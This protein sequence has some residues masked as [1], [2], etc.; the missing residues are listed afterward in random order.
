MSRLR[1]A[2][3]SA[4][5]AALIVA[6]LVFEIVTTQPVRGAIQTC[7]ELLTI[8][9][10]LEMIDPRR[11]EEKQ[12]ALEA[13]NALCSARF[14]Q[15][16]PLKSAPEG[17]I[18]GIPRNLHKNFRA[19][20]QGPNVWICTVDPRDRFRP[21]Y[22]FVFEDGRWRFDGLVGTLGPHGEVV[23]PEDPTGRAPD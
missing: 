22:Q 18:S 19:W 9:N 16:H 1:I 23:P 7:S 14:R 11:P 12:A 15:A 10:Q 6:V 17:G 5:V 13:A 4:A 3:A 2:L 8:A 21:V 20:R